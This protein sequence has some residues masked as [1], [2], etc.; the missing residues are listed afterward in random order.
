MEIIPL[1]RRP[2][3]IPHV[4][5]EDLNCV[6]P[7]FMRHDPVAK[8]YFGEAVFLGY[9]DYA[10]AGVIDGNV[11]GR[12]FGIPFF[13]G[14]NGRTELPDGGWDQMIR[15]AHEDKLIG[16]APTTMG[17]LE[18]T[19]RPEARGIGNALKMLGALKTC[20][21]NLGFFDIFIPVRPSQ[22][23]LN[24]TIS[25]RDYINLKRSDGAPA[26]S[27]LRT[28]INSG[29]KIVKVAPYSMTIVGSI[30]EWSQWTGI[31]FEQSGMIE[32][33]GALAPVSVSIEQDYAVYVE[34]NIWVQYSM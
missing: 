30:S 11:V 28:H 14:R 5:S 31:P 2:D 23:H 3:L 18:V 13:F 22:K 17:A 29:G 10:F 1:N 24:K 32:V 27:W 15:W 16:R 9:L 12:A 20:A 26:D 6:W 34:P 25:M 21:R 19:L 8:L 4:L 33:D 7:N